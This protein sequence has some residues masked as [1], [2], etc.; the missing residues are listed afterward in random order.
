MKETH[1]DYFPIMR[2]ISL[3]DE[4]D[5]EK[6]QL[7]ELKSLIQSLI[8]SIN[9]RFGSLEEFVR[10]YQTHTGDAVNPEAAT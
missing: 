7:D 5:D 4:E 6:K 9:D 1:I 10:N 3:E 8:Q 2:A